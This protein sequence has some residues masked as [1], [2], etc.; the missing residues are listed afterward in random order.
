MVWS[1]TK[2]LGWR[3]IRKTAL[4]SS[5]NAPPGP[6]RS[7]GTFGKGT[8]GKGWPRRSRTV[9]LT[10]PVPLKFSQHHSC[11]FWCYCLGYGHWKG[12]LLFPGKC[13]VFSFGFVKNIFASDSAP[14]KL[15]WLLIMMV[16]RLLSFWDGNQLSTAVKLWAPFVVFSKAEMAENVGSRIQ[17]LALNPAR[18]QSKWWWVKSVTIFNAHRAGCGST[19]LPLAPN[20]VFQSGWIRVRDMNRIHANIESARKCCGFT[21]R[22]SKHAW[23]GFVVITRLTFTSCSYFILV[24][25]VRFLRFPRWPPWPHWHRHCWGPQATFGRRSGIPRT[26][27]SHDNL[28]CLETRTTE[29]MGLQ[30]CAQTAC[31]CQFFC[32]STCFCLHIFFAC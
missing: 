16:W 13:W 26:G 29:S 5:H 3:F 32:W 14:E 22:I 19:G 2:I 9:G 20:F 24:S 17:F 21:N 28:G 23:I 25:V 8:W 11:F 10:V 4:L 1:T 30:R 27:S 31:F 18:C 15:T 7:Q 12:T 6:Q